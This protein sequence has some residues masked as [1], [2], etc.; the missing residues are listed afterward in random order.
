M[1]LDL[2]AYLIAAQ[3]ELGMVS[4]V[5]R[6]S[7]SPSSYPLLSRH[8]VNHIVIYPGM[9]NPPHLGHLATFNHVLDHPWLNMHVVTGIVVPTEDPPQSATQTNSHSGAEFPISQK[10]RCALWRADDRFPRHALTW[11]GIGSDLRRFCWRLFQV[12]AKAGLRLTFVLLVEGRDIFTMAPFN[13]WRELC[14]ETVASD[15][16]WC[17]HRK[18]DGEGKKP[19]RVAGF[20]A[21]VR[22]FPPTPQYQLA[23]NDRVWSCAAA[24]DPARKLTLA[25]P[26]KR[27]IDA[28]GGL[29]VNG[30]RIWSMIENG[31]AR[32]MLKRDDGII[33]NQALFFHLV[34]TR[35]QQAEKMVYWAE[36]VFEIRPRETAMQELER[37]LR[38]M[39]K[40][41]GKAAR[42]VDST[43]Y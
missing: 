17:L 4:E 26:C 8:R 19:D 13:E 35:R 3:D 14:R 10:D 22:Q 32:D 33:L 41:L 21:W 6:P 18:D 29:L 34:G 12:M 42:F 40:T 1:R 38:E 15:L 43:R 30:A 23:A 39:G 5:N 11:N 7:N 37:K 25:C 16:R 28:P 20:G 27:H 2:E 31:S 9:F 36:P 24:G